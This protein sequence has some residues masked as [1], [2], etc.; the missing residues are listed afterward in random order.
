MKAEF[1]GKVLRIDE[2]KE[3]SEK[4]KFQK[5]HVVFEDDK[6][7][8]IYDVQFVNQSCDTVK[9]GL[10]YKFSINVKG[11]EFAK[12]GEA[13]KVFNTLECWK[14]EQIQSDFNENK[15]DDCLF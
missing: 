3:V 13:V 10:T 8:Q 5:A 4:F 9:K 12:P 2:T 11:R 14:A 6:Y 1:T 7:P 15:D